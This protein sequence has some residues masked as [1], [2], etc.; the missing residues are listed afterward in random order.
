MVDLLANFSRMELKPKM[1]RGDLWTIE[2]GL[3]P[4][5]YTKTSKKSDEYL[6]QLEFAREI[7]L[8]MWNHVESIK[9]IEV[10]RWVQNGENINA[11]KLNERLF[12]NETCCKIFWLFLLI[13]NTIYT[14]KI[15]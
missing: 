13:L 3:I 8:A 4:S 12:Y 11:S 6:L 1:A 15:V 5:S 10:E 7:N 14:R 2:S 9:Q